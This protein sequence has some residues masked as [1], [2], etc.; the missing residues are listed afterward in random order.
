MRI[1]IL[2]PQFP[3]SDG[4][5]FTRIGVRIETLWGALR[6][7]GFDPVVAVDIAAGD[8][9]APASERVASERWNPAHSDAVLVRLNAAAAVWC[10]PGQPLPPRFSRFAGLKIADG[11]TLGDA[12]GL[13]GI[14]DLVLNDDPLK[15]A[16]MLTN[17][18]GGRGEKTGGEGVQVAILADLAPADQVVAALSD[19]LSKHSSRGPVLFRVIHHAADGAPAPSEGLPVEV[20][21]YTS[22]A[23][24]TRLL[25]ACDIAIPVEAMLPEL[26]SALRSPLLDGVPVIL[27]GLSPLGDLVRLCGLGAVM[28]GS[29]VTEAVETVLELARGTDLEAIRRQTA[30]V[31][32]RL[33][34]RAVGALQRLLVDHDSPRGAP[35]PSALRGAKPR[36]L[37]LLEQRSGLGAIRGIEPLEVLRQSGKID[38]YCAVNSLDELTPA[39]RKASYD[40]VWIQRRCS[41]VI[42]SAIHYLGGCLFDIDDNLLAKQTY[43]RSPLSNPLELLNNLRLA[44]SV[45]TTN[46]RLAQRLDRGAGGGLLEKT[47]VVP[48]AVRFS[49]GAA[50]K[51]PSKPEGLLWVSSDNPPLFSQKRAVVSAIQDFSRE[52]GLPIYVLGVADRSLDDD[53]MIRHMGRMSFSEYLRFLEHQPTLI[54]VS[55]IQTIES[56]DVMDF[57]NCKSDIKMVE[58]A[59]FGHI[60][61]YSDVAYYRDSDL[62]AGVLC[63]NTYGDWRDA[64][65]LAFETEWAGMERRMAAIRETRGMA[66]IAQDAWLPALLHAAIP[67]GVTGEAIIRMVEAIRPTER[68]LPELQ[69]PAA[70]TEPLV[71]AYRNRRFAQGDFRRPDSDQLRKDTSRLL[72]MAE[73][74]VAAARSTD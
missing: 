52:R 65:D 50:M 31:C 19:A 68:T 40:V 7:A 54:G 57:I 59:G 47:F 71:L 49:P 42:V 33:N 63:A 30:G 45:V 73:K 70:E 61:V 8:P 58:F 17:V 13:S 74:A 60:G 12:A 2:A 66:T 3:P 11:E 48:N 10:A 72:E 64:L 37:A 24:R 1:V 27:N 38:S 16:G 39:A 28:P 55:P 29:G 25:S 46:Q 43:H 4:G 51:R 6:E 26:G 20:A 62:D 34:A 56:P 21:S 41:P 67:G 44:R 15:D 69:A 35:M 9:M 22:M 14:F 18:G 5:P 36:V 53:E 23:E 32:R